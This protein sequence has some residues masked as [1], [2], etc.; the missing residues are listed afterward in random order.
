LA[1]RQMRGTPTWQDNPLIVPGLL[2]TVG[3]QYAPT[4]AML[5]PIPTWGRTRRGIPKQDNTPLP[6]AFHPY[7]AQ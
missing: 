2:V 3:C 1:Q 6:P 4:I 5:V 7:L